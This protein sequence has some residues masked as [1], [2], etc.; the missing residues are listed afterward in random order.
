MNQ[1]A[2]GQPKPPRYDFS[3]LTF[4]DMFIFYGKTDG[5]VQY[6]SIQQLLNHL[7]CKFLYSNDDDDFPYDDCD[8]TNYKLNSIAKRTNG[9]VP[10]KSRF[11]NDTGLYWNHIS[12]LIHK[13]VST[14]LNL[15]SLKY[16]ESVS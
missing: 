12:F 8:K 4:N 6:Q 5:I 10:V 7:T 1:I 2:Y 11:F 3:K 9:L 14:Y 13:E 15:P 16:I